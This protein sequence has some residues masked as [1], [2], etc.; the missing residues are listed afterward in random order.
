MKSPHLPLNGHT[1]LQ[2][3][4]LETAERELSRCY[5]PLR[6]YSSRTG[7]VHNT[8]LNTIDL[9]KAT[10][11]AVRFENEVRILTREA[12][13]FHVDIPLAGHSVSRIGSAEEISTKPGTAQVF[14]PGERADLQWSANTQQLCVMVDKSAMEHH[15]ATLLGAELS[16]PLTFRT[17]MDLRSPGGA[18]LDARPETGRP[19]IATR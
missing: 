11:G 7:A 12:D 19:R 13:D 18:H 17:T 4:D 6:L 5:L 1:V 2:T 16:R 15:L 10:V 14:M 8:R 9:G 3:R